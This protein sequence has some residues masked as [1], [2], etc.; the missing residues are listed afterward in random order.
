MGINEGSMNEALCGKVVRAVD[1]GYGNVKYSLKHDD[2]FRDVDCDLFPSRSILAGD[3]SLENEMSQSYDTVIINVNGTNYEV[4]KDIAKA[5]ATNDESTILDMQ[6]CMTDAYL[7]R[8]RGALYY[9]NGIDHSRKGAKYLPDSRI[10]SMI[11]GLPVSTA[12]NNDI[13]TKLASRLSGLHPLPDGRS[14]EIGDITVLPQ[15]VGALFEYA[16]EEGIFNTLKD[17]RSLVIDIG[18]NT[19]DWL[20]TDG[21]LPNYKRSDSVNRGMS[22]VIKAIAEEAKKKEDWLTPT[23]MLMRILDDYF[24]LGKPFIVFNKEYDVQNYMSSTKP[25]INEAVSQLVNNV[26][27]GADIQNIVLA[28]GGASVYYHAI[29]DRYPRHT[30]S[31]RNRPVFSN[32]R[33]YQ[34]FGE[35]KLLK[36]IRTARKENGAE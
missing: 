6:F 35:Q 33:G 5:Q 30:I 16:F 17:Q 21:L 29:K 23:G 14:V 26:G 32:V 3:K 24:R 9:M 1:L 11:V 12:K 18:F 28:G 19:F 7:A 10:D 2:A 25:I 20:V 34:L 27:D 4:G 15:P 22:A 36:Q 31:I 8:F 13:R